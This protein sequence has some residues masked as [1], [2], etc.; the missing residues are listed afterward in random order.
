M[1][2]I[3]L[4]PGDFVMAF[5]LTLPVKSLLRFK[6]VCWSWH[7]LILSRR[8]INIHHD[9]AKRSSSSLI[10]FYNNKNVSRRTT[11]NSVSVS[12]DGTITPLSLPPPT[13]YERH[14][15]YVADSCRGMVCF[16]SGLCPQSVVVWNI[17][18]RNFRTFHGIVT[19]R[20]PHPRNHI[21]M[22][23]NRVVIDL[24][25]GFTFLPITNEYK[26]VRVILY[27]NN[28]VYI[29]ITRWNDSMIFLPA[30]EMDIDFPYK[31]TQFGR[32]L[33]AN[34]AIHWLGHKIEGGGPSIVIAFDMIEDKFREISTP[35]NIGDAESCKSYHRKLSLLNGNRLA[36]FGSLYSDTPG[37][38]FSYTLWALNDYGGASESWA[39]QYT[40]ETLY[41]L[42]PMGF[43][44]NGEV[45]VIRMDGSSVKMGLYDCHT[46]QIKDLP[47]V[48]NNEL[49][50]SSIFDYKERS[51][52]AA[53]GPMQSHVIKIEAGEDVLAKIMS[54]CESTSKSVCVL[55]A[56]GSIS[57]VLLRQTSA[58]ETYE[59]LFQIIN[60]SGS[61]SVL[62][63]GGECSTEGGLTVLF[64][65]EADGNIWGGSVAGLL[66]AA[67]AVQVIVGSFSTQKQRPL[68]SDTLASGASTSRSAMSVSGPDSP[69]DETGK[70]RSSPGVKGQLPWK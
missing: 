37:Y 58:I 70:K 13:L 6:S 5:L 59:G 23:S 1:N 44:F 8:F 3:V 49:Y 55:S 60:L 52:P 21:T 24:A 39:K 61:F 32:C 22:R 14:K 9:G 57:K 25:T 28:S 40:F 38:D 17:A 46:D 65:G 45:V 69:P 47:V 33:N 10:C 4:L 43:C 35:F 16:S 56:N 62:E 66:T 27:F 54:F 53:L 63:S 11:Y 41:D 51:K 29:R 12:E 42:Q 7:D 31:I 18:T 34:D 36:I 15:I 2:N 26:L 67:T 48:I 50:Y 30:K 68:K 20:E 19:N 64:G